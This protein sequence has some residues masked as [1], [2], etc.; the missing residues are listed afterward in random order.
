MLTGSK[1]D[2]ERDKR[3]TIA[4]TCKYLGIHRNTLSKYADA[5]LIEPVLHAATKKQYYT[6]AEI[7]RFWNSTY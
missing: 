2:V 7:L 4:E 5:H 1:P 6:G 3:Y